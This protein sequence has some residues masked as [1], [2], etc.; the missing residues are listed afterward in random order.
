M[1]R[2]ASFRSRSG[3]TVSSGGIRSDCAEASF[4]KT[5]ERERERERLGGL[6]METR[7]A[8]EGR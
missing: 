7:E 5:R 2:G 4:S 3:E 1:A 8:F 6:L